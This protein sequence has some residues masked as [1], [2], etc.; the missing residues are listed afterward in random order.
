MMCFRQGMHIPHI[1]AEHRSS[2]VTDPT[3][4]QLKG[5]YLN[6]ERAATSRMF[7][8]WNKIRAKCEF[9]LF[10]FEF[11]TNSFKFCF[12]SFEICFQSFSFC[13]DSFDGLDSNCVCPELDLTW[14]YPSHSQHSMTYSVDGGPQL[15]YTHLHVHG[16]HK[17]AI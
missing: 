9:G 4:C 2:V 5:T 11:T 15:Y 16:P 17:V 3:R 7:K 14:S 8:S 6:R 13:F 12:V 10:G 1:L